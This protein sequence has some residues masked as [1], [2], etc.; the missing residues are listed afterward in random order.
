MKKI[1]SLVVLSIAALTLA[2]THAHAG[3]GKKWSDW[4]LT[5]SKA[6]AFKKCQLEVVDGND[7]RLPGPVLARAVDEVLVESLSAARLKP[8][9]LI[10]QR[11]EEVYPG[12]NPTQFETVFMSP[13]GG[14]MFNVA[15]VGNYDDLAVDAARGGRLAFTNSSMS[16]HGLITRYVVK[17]G[18][19]R[20]VTAEDFEKFMTS[21]VLENFVRRFCD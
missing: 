12:S 18:G 10:D 7:P 17:T 5:N 9:V 20:R 15:R 1:Y 11:L 19:H 13:N 21:V 4:L 8:V 6:E 3:P 14:L 16:S 2:T